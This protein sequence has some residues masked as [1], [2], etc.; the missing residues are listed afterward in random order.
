V[1]MGG[2]LWRAGPGTCRRNRAESLAGPTC[3]CQAGDCMDFE[4]RAASPRD[5]DAAVPLIYSSGQHEYDYAFGTRGHPAVDWIHTAFLTRSTTE[6]HQAFRVAV[7]DGRV[8]GI[9]SFL[10]GGRFDTVNALRLIWL[11]IRFYGLLECWGAIRRTLQLSG[12][13]PAPEKGA[14]YIQKMGVIPEARG[15]GVG[16]ALLSDAI[17]SARAAGFRRCVLDVAVTNPRAQQ[18]YERLGFHVTGE[19]TLNER[20]PSQRRMELVL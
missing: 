10:D 12:Q 16:T 4:I 3:A 2:R 9:G 19:R 14:L 15:K 6:S 17:T 20:V 7:I 13:M 8:V 5:V 11:G 1:A 18:L